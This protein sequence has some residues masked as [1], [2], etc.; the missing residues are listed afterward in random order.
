MQTN[1]TTKIETKIEVFEALVDQR[2]GFKKRIRELNNE[3]EKLD[4]D[5]G[6]RLDEENLK[7]VKVREWTVTRRAPSAGRKT[8]DVNKLLELGVSP[9][10]IAAATTI[11]PVGKP[12]ISVRGPKDDEEDDFT[13]WVME[14]REKA[15]VK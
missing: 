3:V 8:V 2:Q 9:Q 1:G 13:K 15:G 14:V 4:G 6:R 12:S 7:S 10:I 5:L 11:G